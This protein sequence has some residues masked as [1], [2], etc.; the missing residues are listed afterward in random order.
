MLQAGR[1]PDLAQKPLGSDP[2]RHVRPHDLDRHRTVVP[3]VM[4]EVDGRHA[5]AAELPTELDT[6]LKDMCEG[7]VGHEAREMGAE[8]VARRRMLSKGGYTSA[9]TTLLL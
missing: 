9:D 2:C 4:R 5:A 8:N 1:H 7:S 3:A 6:I